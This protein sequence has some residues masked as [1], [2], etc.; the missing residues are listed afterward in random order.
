M[1]SSTRV[2]AA[3]A[4]KLVDK[5]ALLFDVRNPVA[6]RNGSLPGAVNISPRTVSALLKHPKNTKMVFFGDADDDGSINTIINYVTQMGFQ[7]IYT[8]GAMENWDK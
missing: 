6:F 1:Y 7:D 4:K 3:K 5:G 8:F 2:T